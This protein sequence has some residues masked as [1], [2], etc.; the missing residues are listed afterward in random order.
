MLGYAYIYCSL[1]KIRRSDAFSVSQGL[2]Y[3][4]F[5]RGSLFAFFALLLFFSV[6]HRVQIQE[7]LSQILESV[8]T[9]IKYRDY[10]SATGNFCC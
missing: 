6:L 7:D 8:F 1:H 2:F 5:P 3:S 4:C 10:I 9:E